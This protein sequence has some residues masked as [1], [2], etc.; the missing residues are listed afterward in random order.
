MWLVVTVGW[1]AASATLFYW[2]AMIPSNGAGWYYDKPSS[3]AVG[4]RIAAVIVIPPLGV[5]CTGCLIIWTTTGLKRKL[6][7]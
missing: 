6:T 2:V 7:N 3:V 5:L 4:A 1:V